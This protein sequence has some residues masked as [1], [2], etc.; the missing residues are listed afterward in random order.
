MLD[1]QMIL[2][3]PLNSGYLVFKIMFET[4]CPSNK[5]MQLTESFSLI[6]KILLKIPLDTKIKIS[7]KFH[8]TDPKC[9]DDEINT[10]ENMR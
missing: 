6:F 5:C 7:R 10:W 1:Y 3:R 4:D 2:V 9:K 8:I